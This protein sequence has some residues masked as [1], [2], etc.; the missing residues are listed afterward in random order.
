MLKLISLLTGTKVYAN[1]K[2]IKGRKSGGVRDESGGDWKTKKGNGGYSTW[3][4]KD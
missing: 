1:H 4:D 3:Y 2:A